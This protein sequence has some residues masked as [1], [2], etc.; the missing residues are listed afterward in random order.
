MREKR[1]NVSREQLRALREIR[2][3]CTECSGCPLA[4]DDNFLLCKLMM[5]GGIPEK[6]D[7]DGLEVYDEKEN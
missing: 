6:W 1:W 5:H 7:L 4:C 3:N 2:D